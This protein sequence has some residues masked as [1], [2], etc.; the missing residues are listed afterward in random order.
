ML[1][2]MLIKKYKVCKLTC[3]MTMY[4]LVCI[5]AIVIRSD[6]ENFYRSVTKMTKMDF[7]YVSF[8]HLIYAEKMVKEDQGHG[9]Q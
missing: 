8:L 9:N 2:K 7:V 6:L 5:G 1:H 3:Q 4:G